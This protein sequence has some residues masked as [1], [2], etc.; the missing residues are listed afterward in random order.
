MTSGTITRIFFA[1][2]FGIIV[3]ISGWNYF[4]YRSIVA[5]EQPAKYSV[6]E[7]KIRKGNGRSYDLIVRL[8]GQQYTVAIDEEMYYDIDNEDFPTMYYIKSRDKLIT[9]WHVTFSLRILLIFGG[10]FVICLMP[11]NKW[12]ADKNK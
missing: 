8:N 10:F 4:T 2:L 11:W 5:H 7:K 9:H 12:L 6:V 3:I 1:V